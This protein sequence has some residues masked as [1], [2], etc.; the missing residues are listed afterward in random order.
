MADIRPIHNARDHKAALAEIDA[1]LAVPKRSKDQE[2]QL[3]LLTIVVSAYEDQAF[4]V[5]DADPIDLLEGH[6]ENSG[7]SQ[8]DLAEILGS[9]SLASLILSRQRAMS[10]DVI[11]TISTEW[12]IPAELLIKPYDLAKKRA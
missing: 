2:E 1:L 10:L 12:G 4:A 9:R 6:M 7:R 11:R 5:P 3:E 8:K